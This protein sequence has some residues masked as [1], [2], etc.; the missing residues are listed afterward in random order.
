ML[1]AY[2]V[3]LRPSWPLLFILSMSGQRYLPWFLLQLKCNQDINMFAWNC[4]LWISSKDENVKIYM[5]EYAAYVSF[6]L[7]KS[8]IF[9]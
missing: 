6:Q 8:S 4:Q 3:S 9:I 5:A 2:I 1:F 7:P